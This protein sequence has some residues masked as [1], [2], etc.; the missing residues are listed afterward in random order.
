MDDGKPLLVSITDRS[1][2][3]GLEFV[4][5]GEG[6]WAEGTGRV[7]RGES[8]L[9]AQLPADGFRLGPA[10]NWLLRMALDDG[11]VFTLKRPVAGEL[12]IATSGWSG[13][14]VPI[15]H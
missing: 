10:A 3:L 6:L 2:G 7:C 4:K 14:F 8:G 15:A 11:A 12:D 13:R 9:E 1:D 5:H